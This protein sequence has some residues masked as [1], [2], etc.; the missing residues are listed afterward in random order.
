MSLFILATLAAFFIKG[1]CGFAN[2]LVFQSILSFGVNNAS[3][4]PVELAL[5]FPGNVILTWQNRKSLNPKVFGPLM[6][7]MLAGNL[8][9][10]L[11]LSSIDGRIVKIIFGA[12]IIFIA[13]DMLRGQG[14]PRKEKK[15]MTALVGVA[16]GVLSGLFGV[17]ALLAAYISRITETNG[18][19]K[20]NI[21]VVFLA[22]N[23][24]RFA[25]YAALGILNQAA[26]ITA[27]KLMPFMLVSLFA[28]I[29]VSKKIDDRR[30]RKLVL[31]L[32]V[33]SGAML[34]AQN[35]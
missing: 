3:I 12:A 8:P 18:A 13:L 10:A 33:V 27:V 5:G 28:G 35:L 31:L 2:T 9:G 16:A 32:L 17:G 34:I 7:L 19:F 23:V 15:W 29:A 24:F 21:S 30:I 11:M 1:L 26:L 14:K 22:E 6:A 25:L 20:A 4:S